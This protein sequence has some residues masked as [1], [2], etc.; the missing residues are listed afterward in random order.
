MVSESE[1]FAEEDRKRKEDVEVRNNADAVIYQAE[2]LLKDQGDKV[3]GELKSEVEE[4]IT[5]VRTAVQGQDAGK[6]REVTQ[7]LGEAIQRLGA[8][9]Y[10]EQ[11]PPPSD[12]GPDAGGA[13]AGNDEDVIEGEFREA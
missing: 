4:K 8:Q 2:K 10:E 13:D 11:T 7:E 3:S 12:G 1:R 5:V 6:I 9:M